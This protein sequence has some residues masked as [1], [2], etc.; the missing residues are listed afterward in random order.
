[1][2]QAYGNPKWRGSLSHSTSG[3]VSAAEQALRT[4]LPKS[5]SSRAA[6]ARHG[7]T[8]GSVAQAPMC[9]QL[10]TW[11]SGSC[12]VLCQTGRYLAFL[13]SAFPLPGL[14]YFPF[15]P[16]QGKLFQKVSRFKTCPRA[17]SPAS[18]K[19]HQFQ[20]QLFHFHKI[21]LTFPHCYQ[22]QISPWTLL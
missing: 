13:G 12:W 10:S 3:A 9:P 7:S 19:Q 18:Y 6:G 14:L 21:F 20:T 1:M 22:L 15:F 8:C 4:I 5:C 2:L 16:A 17:F 11:P